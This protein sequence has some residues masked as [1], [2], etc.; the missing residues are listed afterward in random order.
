MYFLFLIA[1]NNII[2][3]SGRD[4]T[5]LSKINGNILARKRVCLSIIR[6]LR[7]HTTAKRNNLS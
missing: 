1:K 3:F 4:I 7:N 2:G 6:Q 5:N